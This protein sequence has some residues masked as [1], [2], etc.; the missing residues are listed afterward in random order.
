MGLFDAVCH[1]LSTVSIGG[2]STHDAS[3][4]FFDSPAVEGVAVIF[5]VVSAVN[6]G[7]HFS[8]L[9]D[10]NPLLYFR[11][12]EFRA[13]FI[14]LLAGFILVSGVLLHEPPDT[15]HPVLDALFQVVSMMTT[16]GFT[17][18]DYSAWPA[19]A[20]ILLIL[21]SFAGGCAGSTAGGLKVVRVL[22]LFLQGIR[23]IRLLIHPTAVFQVKLGG[24]RVSDKIISAVW[25]FF[26]VYALSFFVLLIL[27]ALFSGL[28]FESSFS[29]VAACLNNLGPGLGDVS[30]NFQSVNVPTKWILIVAMILGRLE[31]F[32]ILVLLSPLYWRR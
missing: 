16:T 26:A 1:A 32:T 27:V 17:S 15:E 20:S 31:I 12:P 19:A 28:D 5:M 6:F 23:E 30:A 24:S 8:V 29:A 9:R 10:S 14:L 21:A 7:L 11:D 2:F 13:M 25:S 22:L 18:T 4:G 3:M